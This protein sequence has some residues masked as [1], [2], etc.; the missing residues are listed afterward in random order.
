[1]EERKTMRSNFR[2]S[3]MSRAFRLSLILVFLGLPL[4]VVKAEEE[5]AGWLPPSPAEMPTEFDWVQLPS[6][7][8]LGGEIIVLYEDT[9]E[10]DS[11]EMGITK[12]DWED[13]VE[14][15]SVQV[16]EVRPREGES[17]IGKVLIKDGKVTVMGD[18]TA[19]FEQVEIL[20]VTA[21]VPK[22]INFWSGEVSASA[23]Y[24]SGNTDKESFN[25]RATVQRRTVQQRIVLDYIGN[26]DE[27]ENE[28]TENNHR[29]SG[30]WD[31]FVTD[32]VFWS[33]VVAEYY[34]DKFQNI[35]HR[36]TY[37]VAL[38]YEIIDTSKTEW[39]VS[40]GPGYT[41]T[42]FQ[43]VPEGES[44]SEGSPA[45]QAKTRFDHEL[46]DDIDIWY[47]YRALF[48]NKDTG[49]YLHRMETGIAY[50]IIDDF[51]IRAT[52]VWD[53]IAEPAE[54]ENGEKPDESDTQLF[55]GIGY[56]F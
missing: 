50:E 40:G 17:M 10:F 1:M 11:D 39:R 16:L 52:W 32:R 46:T 5:A 43:D 4:T 33:P 2:S 34:K 30:D 54:D 49:Q 27:T 20:S 48:T 19:V 51:D 24:Q 3:V 31:R 21:G 25:G 23:N 28:E 36:L 56:T 15:R 13:V 53:Y 44:D 14:L 29:L 12:I 7:E 26:Y 37:G 41:K 47:D 38:G 8:W 45:F 9:L 55:F 42:W 22:E 6:G 35:E 18:Q